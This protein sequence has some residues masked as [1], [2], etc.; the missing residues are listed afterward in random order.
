[1]S[2]YNFLHLLG[3][4]VETGLQLV[5]S[6][7]DL[8]Q[9]ASTPSQPQCHPS[10]LVGCLM[11]QRQPLRHSLDA[12]LAAVASASPVR[13]PASGRVQG[14]QKKSG[15]LSQRFHSLW[16]ARSPWVHQTFYPQLH[17]GHWHYWG[18]LPMQTV[19]P[20]A[21]HLN[22]HFRFAYLLAAP[23]AQGRAELPSASAS[24]FSCYV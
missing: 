2:C 10:D 11:Q 14:L 6:K 5:C 9:I 8:L 1:M 18:T 21:F 17:N 12:A 7:T 24:C 22:A 16:P 4:G 13:K 20:S 19:C 15:A 3:E 23:G